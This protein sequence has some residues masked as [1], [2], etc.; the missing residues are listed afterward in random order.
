LCESFESVLKSIDNR[1]AANMGKLKQKINTTKMLC[2]PK[3]TIPNLTSHNYKHHAHKMPQH[4][5]ECVHKQLD[6]AG[7]RG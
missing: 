6:G 7:Q 4:H 5:G 3:R 2:M 1:L